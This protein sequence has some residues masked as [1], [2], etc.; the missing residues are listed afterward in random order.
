VSL[1]R[2][3]LVDSPGCLPVWMMPQQP[4]KPEDEQPDFPDDDP[5]PDF[6]DDDPQPDFDPEKKKPQPPKK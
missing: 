5:Q 2:V 1:S 6:P 3:P 4:Q